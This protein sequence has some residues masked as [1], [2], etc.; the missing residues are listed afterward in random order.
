MTFKLSGLAAVVF[1]FVASLVSPASAATVDARNVVAFEF[2]FS[3]TGVTSFDRFGY[4][5]G[6]CGGEGL[7]LS[8][9]TMQLDFGTTLGAA[10]IGSRTF[11]NPFNFAISNVSSGL[12]PEVAV[13][14]AV[15]RLFLT[16]RFVDDVFDISS[17]TIYGQSIGVM[18]GTL[19]ENVPPSPVPLPAG[20]FLMASALGGLAFMKR[21]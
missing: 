5:C 13:P 12:T 15:D 8:G 16:F 7:F 17:A 10:D 19:I 2:D 11:S 1:V 21:K 14:G 4:N 9:A 20:I 18:N 3:T 6:R